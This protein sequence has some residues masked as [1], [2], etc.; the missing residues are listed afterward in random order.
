MPLK[1]F[2]KEK[3]NT[4]RLNMFELMKQSHFTQVKATK[5]VVSIQL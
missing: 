5:V 3:N 4:A 1:S 2:D